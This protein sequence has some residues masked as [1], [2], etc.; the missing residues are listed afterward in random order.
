MGHRISFL[1]S[2]L[3]ILVS[4]DALGLSVETTRVA[5]WRRG[6]SIAG[7]EFIAANEGIIDYLA[8]LPRPS[9]ALEAYKYNCQV[10][11]RLIRPSLRGISGSGTSGMQSG[12]V[13]VRM[14][15]ELRDCA[16]AD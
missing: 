7:E 3:A 11:S 6:E 9:G 4:L 13:E 15:Y 14:V 1:I 12:Y 5:L 2:G 10:K 8:T 16:K